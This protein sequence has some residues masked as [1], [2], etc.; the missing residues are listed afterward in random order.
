MAGSEKQRGK[1][2]A[3]T[4]GH[5]RAASLALG[6]ALGVL[7]EICGFSE[8]LSEAGHAWMRPWMRRGCFVLGSRCCGSAAFA[9]LRP[10]PTRPANSPAVP[11]LPP[12]ALGTHRANL[13]LR[14]ARFRRP[15]RGQVTVAGT[16]SCTRSFGARLAEN[17]EALTAMPQKTA[18]TRN[19]WYVNLMN[20][21]ISQLTPVEELCVE[22]VNVL[23]VTRDWTAGYPDQWNWIKAPTCKACL[24]A[25][26]AYDTEVV[27]EAGERIAVGPDCC[28]DPDCGRF[29]QEPDEGEADGPMMDYSYE[30]PAKHWGTR[31][32]WTRTDAS[33]IAHLPLVI[34]YFNGEPAD[35]ALALSGAG[36]DLSWEICEAFMRL[37]FLPPAHFASLPRMAGMPKTDVYRWVIAGCKRSLEYQRDRADSALARLAD[38]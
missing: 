38:F 9:I 28:Q 27:T 35:A 12:R 23:P 5:A 11:A 29:G 4:D 15:R 30:L 26:P 8:R 1:A 19:R 36:M 2:K 37:G 21:T 32:P 18:K 10:R 34:V 7:A 6:L 16:A 22:S 31:D 24:S 14:S 3:G 25:C 17:E 20:S 33:K 13:A